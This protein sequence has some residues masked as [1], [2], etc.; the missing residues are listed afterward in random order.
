MM[1]QFTVRLDDDLE[2]D[3]D[4]LKQ[5]LGLKIDAEV[6][7]LLIKKYSMELQEATA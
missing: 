5:N 7:R 3:F 4:A 6:V 2:H 1:K